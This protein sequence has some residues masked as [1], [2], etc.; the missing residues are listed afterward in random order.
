MTTDANLQH[1]DFYDL[2]KV[3][4]EMA[5]LQREMAKRNQELVRLSAEKNRLLG[6][7]A[8]DLRNPLGVISAYAEFL[9]VEAADVLDPE[10]REFVVAIREASAF[11]LGLV[12]DLLDISVIEAGQLKLRREP[13]DLAALVEHCVK[14][15]RVLAAKKAISINFAACAALPQLSLDALK[16]KQVLNNVL[17]NAVKFS[18]RGGFVEVRITATEAEVTVAVIDNGPGIP[19]AEMSKLFTPFGTAGA[20]GTAGEKSTGLGLAIAR[21]VVEGHGGRIWVESE[22]GSGSTFAF[23]LPLQAA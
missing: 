6:M 21:R 23:T 17:D 3:N 15:S 12:T 10:Q 4:N 20:R 19:A 1:H 8:H 11:M 18:D 7:A 5:N 13:V 22:E 9:E 16:I 2:S 14:M